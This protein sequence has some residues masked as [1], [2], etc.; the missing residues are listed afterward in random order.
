MIISIIIPIYNRETWIEQMF[1]RLLDLQLNQA[2]VIIVD[3]GSTDG[4][5]ERLQQLSTDQFS[6]KI[7]KQVNSGPATARNL[8]FKHSTGKYIQYLDSDDFLMPNKIAEQIQYMESHSK[9]DVVYGSWRMG[10]EWETGKDMKCLKNN[11][12]V[13]GLLEGKWNPPFSYLFRRNIVELVGGWGEKHRL[14]DDFDFALRVAAHGANFQCVPTQITGFY[15]W[16]PYERLSR[17]SDTANALATYPMLK[18]AISI[19]EKKN[20]LGACRRRAFASC[21]WNLAVKALPASEKVFQEGLT[22]SCEIDEGALPQNL[23][24]KL[25]GYKS[26][27]KIINVTKFLKKKLKKVAIK[28]GV[29]KIIRFLRKV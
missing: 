6:I 17:Q 11:D 12:M 3:D 25:L 28:M 23:I 7:F 8:G 2:E 20:D 19:C 15:C 18:D 4:T 1:Q 5:F 9:V 22:K 14:N 13:V 29:R 27:A 16:H 26:Y 24:V 10:E 21:F